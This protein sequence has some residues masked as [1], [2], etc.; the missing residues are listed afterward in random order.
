MR[1]GA[2][3]R[4]W[5]RSPATQVCTEVAATWLPLDLGL[6]PGSPGGDLAALASTEWQ[7][8]TQQQPEQLR[9]LLAA[10]LLLLER[11]AD[12]NQR[13]GGV[14]PLKKA[15]AGPFQSAAFRPLSN[16]AAVR[17]LPYAAL[18]QRLQRVL[19]QLQQ[20]MPSLQAQQRQQRTA[21]AFQAAEA[22]AARTGAWGERAALKRHSQP[23]GLLRAVPHL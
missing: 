19:Q 1:C 20:A 17:A 2:N 12:A 10:L 9:P 7:A 3:A 13:R 18:A 23:Q 11:R 22:R 6:H 5:T 21:Q 15:R 4:A 16:P 8:A 14:G